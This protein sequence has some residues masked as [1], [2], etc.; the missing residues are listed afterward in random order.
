MTR[1][2][3]DR[4]ASRR[5]RRTGTVELPPQGAPRPLRLK[6][7]RLQPLAQ[8]LGAR[9]T[10]TDH[11]GMAR[12]GRAARVEPP[13]R[14]GSARAAI[15]GPQPVPYVGAMA[16]G[17]VFRPQLPPESLRAAVAAAE[18]AGRRGALAVGG[19]LPRGR[20][21]RGR[22]R[23]RLVLAA[24]GRDRAA[25]RAVPQPGAG[26]HG[27]RHPRPAVPRPGH[28]DARPRRARLD[29]PGR[30][31]RRVPDDAAARAR[32]RRPRAPARR[33]GHRLRPLRLPRRRRSS[34]GRPPS[35]P[36]CSSAPAARRPSPS[37]PR[38]P[39]ASCSTP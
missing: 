2:R 24:D 38:S 31:R 1:L 3:R 36:P 11:P 10:R 4:V 25:A 33:V 18:D 9:T 15:P 30:R 23:A 22:R 28:R 7:K 21:D 27:D 37:P 17:V 20:P 39:T 34:T 16:T 8:G 32:L 5:V 26:R 14:A 13:D 12:P 6:R 35:R 29:A 19:L